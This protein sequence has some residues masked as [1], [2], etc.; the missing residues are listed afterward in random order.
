MWGA[1]LACG[2]E[3]SQGGKLRGEGK[4]EGPVDRN[5][6]RCC[7]LRPLRRSF[8]CQ[9]GMGSRREPGEIQL[10][11]RL[12]WKVNGKTE[13]VKGGIFCEGCRLVFA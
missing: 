5:D 13:K 9:W 3:G 4:A 8:I 7:R 11:R 1:D 6:H 12:L 2:Q 10:P